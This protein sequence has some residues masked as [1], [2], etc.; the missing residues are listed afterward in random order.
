MSRTPT[1]HW[2]GK[3]LDAEPEMRESSVGVGPRQ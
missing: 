2:I 1:D 3:L